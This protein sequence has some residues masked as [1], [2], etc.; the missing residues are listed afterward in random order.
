MK[1][2]IPTYEVYQSHDGLH[3]RQLWN[4]IG[5]EWVCLGCGRSKFQIMKWTRRFPNT[6]NSF[7]GWVAALHK[8]HDHSIGLFESGQTR[9]PETLVCGQCN[10]ADGTVKRKLKLPS[11][12]SFSPQEMRTFI[13]ATPHG[14]HEI[15]YDLALTIFNLLTTNNGKRYF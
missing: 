3:Y 15:N 14:K 8:H 2:K 13:R 9:F 5:D 4:S 11:N 6:P 10:S 1:I 12:F 7:M